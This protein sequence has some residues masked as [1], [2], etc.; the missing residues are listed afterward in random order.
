MKIDWRLKNSEVNPV[1]THGIGGF[2][3]RLE[4]AAAPGERSLKGF[5]FL[6]DAAEMLRFTREIEREITNSGAGGPLYVGFQNAAKLEKEAGR[7]RRMRANGVTV[8][9]F[10]EG[11]PPN[12][13]A[14][15]L[16]DWTALEPD[17]SLLQ[18]QWLLVT[19]TPN[20][21]AFVG[22]EVSPDELWG[23]GGISSAGKAF[24]GFVSDDARA[25]AVIV[26]HLEDVRLGRDSS[27]S[28]D[29]QIADL[30]SDLRPR[31]IVALTDEGGRP[32]LKRA[33]PK[34]AEAGGQTGAD[35]YLYDLSAASY[36]VSPYPDD[37]DRWH[38]PQ[39]SQALRRALGRP[40]LADEVEAASSGGAKV[41]GILPY[42]IGF[43][44]LL[45]WCAKEAI[46]TVV[47]PVE[48]TQP[49]LIERLQGI[50]LQTLTEQ[51]SNVTIIVDDPVRGPWM[52][53]AAQ[54]VRDEAR[55]AR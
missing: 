50:S 35:I 31:R 24:A 45:E 12:E 47:V 38:K 25:V 54:P 18:N 39:T 55:V 33:L 4:M 23:R 17:Y 41:K 20:P 22:W 27:K 32:F 2:L 48:F 37:D 21:I 40:A 5:R 6:Q 9:G 52:V 30:I 10:G 3:K 44:H 43:G 8:Y 16:A 7:Y 28:P 29:G 19:P 26:D 15:G 34:I 51:K 14:D 53:P 11:E 13:W 46:D 49:S 1:D 36:L 42:K